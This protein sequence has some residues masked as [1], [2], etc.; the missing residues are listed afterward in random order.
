MFRTASKMI[1]RDGTTHGISLI[2][3]NDHPEFASLRFDL[4][5]LSSWYNNSDAANELRE[6]NKQISI[7]ELARTHPEQTAPYAPHSIRNFTPLADLART[8]KI[9]LKNFIANA[10]LHLQSNNL[11]KKDHFYAEETIL[12]I[13][14][15]NTGNKFEPPSE[16]IDATEE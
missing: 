13:Y 10:R 2:L 7:E 5:A 8:D 6:N 16:Q 3:R 15:E 11:I 12:Q 4:L 9:A 1:K 14:E